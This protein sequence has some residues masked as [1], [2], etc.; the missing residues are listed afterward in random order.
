MKFYVPNPPELFKDDL[1][2]SSTLYKLMNE[3][4][5]D[6]G[7]VYIFENNCSILS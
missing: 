5:L 3:T 6:A 2:K 4:L 1:Y 7:I